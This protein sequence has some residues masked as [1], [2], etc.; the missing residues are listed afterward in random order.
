MD[1]KELLEKIATPGDA[2]AAGIGFVVGLPIDYFL[3]HMGVPPGTVSGYTAVAGWSLKKPIDAG[4]KSRRNRRE[5]LGAEERARNDAKSEEE[6]KRL[7][8]EE[9]RHQ[10]SE[11]SENLVRYLTEEGRQDLLDPFTTRLKL[12]RYKLLDDESFERA[13]SGTVSQCQIRVQGSRAP[14]LPEALGA[15]RGDEGE[16]DI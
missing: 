12:W 7:T 3:L 13:I 6:A 11:Q 14:R 8:Q 9:R 16:N 15:A 5:S 10:L 1:A 4:L 2:A